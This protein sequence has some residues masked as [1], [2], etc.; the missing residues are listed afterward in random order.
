MKVVSNT[1]PLILLSKIERLELLIQL[2]GEI[3][4]PP[5]VFAEIEEKPGPE[6]DAIRRTREAGQIRVQSVADGDLRD[7]P[8]ELGPGE[9]ESIAL[10]LGAGAELILLDDQ[11][12]RVLARSRG[13]AVAGTVGVLVE[14]KIRGHLSS[15]RTEL[16]RLVDVGFWL[17]ESLYDRVLREVGE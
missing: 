10:A 1:S 3:L 14:A 8:A 6:V 9:R 11:E 4:V 2:Y 15:V 16:D 13:L 7:L 17:A 5:A 12:G